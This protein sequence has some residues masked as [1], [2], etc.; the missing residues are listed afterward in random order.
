MNLEQFLIFGLFYFV[1]F[2]VYR[3]CGGF[4]IQFYSTGRMR[5]FIVEVER[6]YADGR[7]FISIQ[8]VKCI[9]LS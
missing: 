4:V 9:P 1:P 7:G 2:V 5:Y 6:L 3:V 8:L